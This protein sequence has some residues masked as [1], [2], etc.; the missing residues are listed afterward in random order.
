MTG[1]S[2]RRH[3]YV[4]AGE[5]RVARP[6]HQNSFSLSGSNAHAAPSSNNAS[7]PLDATADAASSTNAFAPLGVA[8][9]AA[10]SFS[11]SAGGPEPSSSSDAQDDAP[12]TTEEATLIRTLKPPPPG[13]TLLSL[14][15]I[16]NA[17]WSM[18]TWLSE[19][20]LPR[21]SYDTVGSAYR[22]LKHN[23]RVNGWYETAKKQKLWCDKAQVTKVTTAM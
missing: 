20:G 14:P 15:G 16:I 13:S 2:G 18:Q 12:P 8:A 1:E 19:N 6:P 10:A 17:F 23:G 5:G 3:G 9:T 21:A 11:S 22:I 7:A 4:V